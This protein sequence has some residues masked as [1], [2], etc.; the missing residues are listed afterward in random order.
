MNTLDGHGRHLGI[1][2]SAAVRSVE[3]PSGIDT[4]RHC[5]V[6]REKAADDVDIPAQK[7]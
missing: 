4:A 7:I 1:R 3:G 5:R 2:V 6:Q